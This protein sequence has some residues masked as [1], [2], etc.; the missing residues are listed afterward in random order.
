MTAGEL[1]E[2]AEGFENIEIS[3][4][5]DNSQKIIPNGVFVCLKGERYDGH[6]FIA[7]AEKNKAAVIVAEKKLETSARVVYVKDCTAVYAE[8]CEKFYGNPAKKLKLIG[9]TGTNG[10]T[11]VTHLVGAILEASGR[12]TGII[13]TNRCFVS[14]REL[15]FESKMPTTP[16]AGELARI[17]DIMQKEGT[18]YVVMEVSSHALAQKRVHGLEFEVGVFTNLTRDHLDF[19][20]TMENY[21][22]AKEKLF[23]ISK[24]AVINIDTAPGITLASKC[25]IPITTVGIHEADIR[26]SQIMLG[27]DGVEFTVSEKGEE[28]RAALS[29]PGKFSV[30]NA[31]CAIGAARCTKVEYDDI[32]AGLASV[33]NVRGRAEN[34]PTN[35][36]FNVIIDYAH[37]P[38]GLSNILHT[39]KGFTKGRVIAVFGCGGDRDR[40][41]RPIMGE[42]AGSLAD[43]SIITSDNPRTENPVAIVEEIKIGMDKSGGDYII[44]VNRREAIEYALGTAKEN[45]TVVL[46]GKGQ[47]TYQIIGERKVPFDEREIVKKILKKQNGG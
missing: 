35:T 43:F 13:G 38:D 14:G 34:V 23:E 45:D 27:G 21:M 10:K 31:L 30:Y 37:T 6:D 24:K 8:L 33:K 46:C 19:H 47:E 11:T 15:D 29:I 44:I 3:G 22:S 17:F 28:H 20:K 7:E 18:E 25:K 40:T 12:K 5:F 1:F 16:D 4:I 41:K 42:T 2:N 26:A 9:V 39:V 32:C 36:D